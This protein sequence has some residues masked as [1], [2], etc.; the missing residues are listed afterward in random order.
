MQAGRTTRATSIA[1]A[2]ACVL[3]TSAARAD[4]VVLWNTLGSVD[5]IENS[6]VGLD[7]TFEGGGFLQGPAPA[8][9]AAYFNAAVTLDPQ[10]T[11]PREVIPAQEG[12]V[13]FWGRLV[14]LPDAIPP[15]GAGG[16]NPAFLFLS[17]ADRNSFRLAFN[18]NDGRSGG[19]L[20][21]GISTPGSEPKTSC[22]DTFGSYEYADILGTS[23]VEDW[24]HYAMVW[25][26][27]G[28]EGVGDGSHRLAVFLDGELETGFF[29]DDAP[30]LPFGDFTDGVLGLIRSAGTPGNPQLPLGV[31]AMDNLILYDF[32]LTDFD[33]RFTGRPVPEPMTAL[34]LWGGL[35]GLASRASRR[36]RG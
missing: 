7:G 2:L 20:C 16:D 5:E 22:T 35:A 19:G 10:V 12:T 26:Q 32:A 14:G 3:A 33:H 27:D 30:A 1:L 36:R 31:V 15:A 18:P 9:G 21:S 34:L 24:H 4:G 13:E 6:E 23:A 11:F 28:I 8:F 25:D 29:R 17:G